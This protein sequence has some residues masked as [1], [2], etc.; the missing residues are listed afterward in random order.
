M[1][2]FAKAPAARV[3]H[4]IDWGG[5]ASDAPPLAASDWTVAPA[6]PDALRVEAHSFDERATA[7]TL[8]GG[9]SGTSYRVANRVTFAD[10]GV[11]ERSLIVRVDAR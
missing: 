4:R 9:V 7:A 6:G 5:P 11:D 1:S 3:V 2:L 10:G 8:A